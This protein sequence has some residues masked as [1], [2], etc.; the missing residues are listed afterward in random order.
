MGNM[1]SYN[2]LWGSDR[3]EARGRINEEVMTETHLNVPNDGSP[4]RITLTSETC[5]DITL[6]C[7]ILEPILQWSVAVSP[8]DCDHNPVLTMLLGVE[9]KV[10]CVTRLN[11]KRADWE[12][13]AGSRAW[14]LNPEEMLGSAEELLGDIIIILG[15]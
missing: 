4:T 15:V 11:L 13:Y 10:V 14:R 8:Y 9:E 2:T 3:T 7:P 12:V 5:I 1:N 6:V